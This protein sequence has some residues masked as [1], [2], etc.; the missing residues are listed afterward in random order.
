MEEEPRGRFARPLA[1][2]GIAREIVLGRRKADG[3]VIAIAHPH[4]QCPVG[5]AAFL[6]RPR[7]LVI[8]I[9]ALGFVGGGLLDGAG[10]FDVP[11]TCGHPPLFGFAGGRACQIAADGRNARHAGW[12]GVPVLGL[13]A[14]ECCTAALARR[15]AG[16]I[17]PFE[18]I[19]G[20]GRY[21]STNGLDPCA[22][23]RR[24]SVANQGRIRPPIRLP[25][26]AV[27]QG[28]D[29][30]ERQVAQNANGFGIGDPTH[31]A[32]FGNTINSDIQFGCSVWVQWKSA[33][34]HRQS[35]TGHILRGNP[36]V[37]TLPHKPN[38][39]NPASGVNF[40]SS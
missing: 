16:T 38:P 2:L 9:V 29:Q 19:V 13:T 15:S 37:G 27:K 34:R 25:S 8:V 24:A 11:E 14:I 33:M 3:E 30:H 22:W 20:G 6:V 4:A 1:D 28:P 17:E 23:R 36:Q 18:P 12:R 35:K 31:D 32:T 39:A 10:R 40:R 7:R 26:E 21:P 5:A